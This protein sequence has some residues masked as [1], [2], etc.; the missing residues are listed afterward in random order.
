MWA[1]TTTVGSDD[2]TTTWWSAFSDYYTLEPNQTLTISF[3][4]Y[5][6]KEQ[7]WFN[8]IGVVTTDA[9]RGASG[10]SEYVILRADNAGWGDSWVIGNLS[11]YYNWETFKDDMDEATVAM[12]V[13]RNGAIVTIHADITKAGDSTPSYWEEYWVACGTGDQNIR[14]FLTTEKGHLTDITSSIAAN[15]NTSTTTGWGTLNAFIDFSNAIVSNKVDGRTNSMS[16]LGSRWVKGYTSGD[17][18]VTV[19]GDVIRVGNGSGTVTIADEELAGNRDEVVISFDYWFG[20]LSGKSAGFALYDNSATPVTI[21]SFYE[22]FFSG[23]ASENTLGFDVSKITSIGAGSAENDKICVD[24]NK[25]RIEIHLNYATGKM[26]ALQYTNGGWQQTTTPVDIPVGAGKFK[27]FAVRSGYTTDS[28]LCWFDNLIIQTKRGDY[29][30][31]EVGY[32]VKFVDGNGAKVK[33]DVTDREGVPGTT[34][35]DL[36]SSDDKTTF[37]NDGAIANNTFDEFAGATNKY[38]YKS[39]SAVNSSAEPITELEADAVITIVY[40]KYNK[41][42]YSVKQKLGTAA[43]TDKET[44]TLWEDQTFS[45]YFPVGVKDNSDYYFTE[46]NGSS[47]YFQTTVTSTEPTVT[48]NYTLDPT[49]VFYSEGEDLESKTDT[50][51]HYAAL[52]ANGSCGV[53]NANDGNLVVNLSAGIYTITARTVGRGDGDGRKVRF[54]KSSV[55]GANELLTATP[56]YTTGNTETSDAFALTSATDILVKG[57]AGGGSNGNGLDYV[58]IK[59]LP[60]NVTATFTSA[61][62]STLYT[63]YALDFSTLSTEIEAYTATL[64]STTVTLNKVDDV[65]ANTGVV[66]KKIGGTDSYDIPVIASSSTPKGDL[67]GNASADTPYDAGTNRYYLAL[68]GESKAQFKKLTSGSIDA[69][70]AFLETVVNAPVLNVV[71]GDENMTGIANVRS[72]MEDVRSDIFDLQGRKVAQ[73][74]KGLY[75][76]N[77]KKVVIK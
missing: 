34:I 72:K 21:A 39:I 36:A 7:N 59:K 26:W 43:A 56:N 11:S 77:G 63:P 53:L 66:L 50:Y 27:S 58:I 33:E 73:P 40:N 44:G 69:G 23:S 52:M 28:R 42:D 29:S 6:N 49:V 22:N 76:V 45:C 15:G 41:Y 10:Y 25:T 35:S 2:N 8:W 62:W 12:T 30:V 24:A 51:T 67:T 31:A 70:K 19:L 14:F 71:F 4:N 20:K 57:A 18:A 60:D 47:P 54:Y 37:Y 65:P 64:S 1:Q 9:D 61:G 68:N 17:P 48:I 75:I 5:T 13:V 32:T 16:L 38:I 46:A 3:K 74:Q 55:D